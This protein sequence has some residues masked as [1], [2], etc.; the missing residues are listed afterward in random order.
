MKNKIVL[1]LVIIFI[2]VFTLFLYSQATRISR[3]LPQPEGMTGKPAS[4]FSEL[5]VDK[6][7]KNAK[8]ND[9]GLQINGP[10]PALEQKNN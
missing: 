4:T 3:T 7:V 2:G 8:K 6:S 9:P 10:V 1:V 5:P